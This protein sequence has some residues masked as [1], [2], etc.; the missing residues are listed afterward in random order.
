MKIGQGMKIGENW[1]VSS[2]VFDF[3][4]GNFGPCD[5]LYI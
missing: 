5:L 1:T 3:G 4:I 2:P